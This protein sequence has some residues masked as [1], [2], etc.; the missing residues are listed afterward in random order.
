M[1]VIFESGPLIT[2]CKYF[3]EQRPIIDII[4]DS[5]EILIAP[6]VKKEVIDEG[7]AYPDGVIAGERLS[8]GKLMVKR[9]DSSQ[10]KI[11]RIY[12]LGEGEIESILLFKNLKGEADFLI[13]D[14]KLAYNVL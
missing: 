6:S 2:A 12:K 3:F 7:K 4:L 14:D 9:V 8:K 1:K 13:V 5:C 10:E 11:L